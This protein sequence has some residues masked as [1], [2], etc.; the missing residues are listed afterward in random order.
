[1]DQLLKQFRAVFVPN[2]FSR[3]YSRHEPWNF[4]SEKRGERGRAEIFSFSQLRV[5]LVGYIT[6]MIGF[7]PVDRSFKW[8]FYTF[9]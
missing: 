6:V 8:L 7:A 5:R 2:A 4:I 9:H 1:V 3:S